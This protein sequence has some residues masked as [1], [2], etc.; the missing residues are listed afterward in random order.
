MFSSKRNPLIL[1]ALIIFCAMVFSS[2]ARAETEKDTVDEPRIVYSDPALEPDAKPFSIPDGLDVKAQIALLAKEINGL[3]ASA[4]RVT[5]IVTVD[6]QMTNPNERQG[7]EIALSGG[8]LK[9]PVKCTT[10]QIGQCIFV[11]NPLEAAEPDYKLFV[12]K[13]LFKSKEKQLRLKPGAVVL[14]TMKL[15]MIQSEL[16]RRIAP[17]PQ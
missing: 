7:V 3:K 11:A 2:A 10:N 5:V 17:P 8:K 14:L 15:N 1:V 12:S 13:E 9:T 6:L 16:D 4:A